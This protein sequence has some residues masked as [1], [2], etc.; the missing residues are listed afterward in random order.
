[1]QLSIYQQ[2]TQLITQKG[3]A[4]VVPV[5]LTYS[6]GEKKNLRLFY[7]TAGDLCYLGPKSR[8]HGYVLSSN[9]IVSFREIGAS[10][11]AKEAWEKP[12]RNFMNFRKKF[13]EQAHPNLWP[14]VQQGYRNA[15]P[16]TVRAGLIEAATSDDSLRFYHVMRNLPEVL[17]ENDYKSTQIG[18][19]MPPNRREQWLLEIKT[20]IEQKQEGRWKWREKYDY[21]VSLQFNGD[22]HFV[23]Y[24][25]Q[26]FKDCGNGHYWLLINPT[27]AVFAESD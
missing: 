21:T 8:R 9:G 10:T 2:L 27:T 16:E 7:S 5:Q 23:G 12:Y 20:A 4:A 14:H 11:S 3:S 24:F 22:G 17:S 13:T 6:D 19:T 18:N 15:D 26:E 1:M 25:S